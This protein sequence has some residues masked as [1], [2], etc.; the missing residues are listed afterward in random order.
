MTRILSVFTANKAFERA[1]IASRAAIPKKTA[2]RNIPTNNTLHWPLLP[3]QN[4][5]HPISLNTLKK[6]KKPWYIF[7]KIPQSPHVKLY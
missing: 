2:F 6:K 4:N 3:H 1:H 7:N 5:I